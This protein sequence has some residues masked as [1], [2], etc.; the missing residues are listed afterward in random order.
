MF[1]SVPVP[2]P[3]GPSTVKV[4]LH[5]PAVDRDCTS[6]PRTER[7]RGRRARAHPRHPR[8]LGPLTGALLSFLTYAIGF[9][10]RPVGALTA[11]RPAQRPVRGPTVAVPR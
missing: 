6:R 10:A 8:S 1:L 4:R 2:S 3:F 5:R 9:A 11:L 7:L